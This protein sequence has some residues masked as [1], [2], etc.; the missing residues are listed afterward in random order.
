[1]P[2]SGRI[3]RFIKEYKESA[4]TER[5]SF[6][7][8]FLIL[9]LEVILI[10]HAISLRETFIIVLTSILLVISII[11]MILVSLEIHEHYQVSNFDRI[12][13]IRLDDFITE[14]RV[15]NVKKIVADFIYMYPEYEKNRTEIYHTTCQILETHKEEAIEKEIY[16]KLFTFV[17][18]K[19]RATVDEIVELF[20]SKYPKF[21]PYRIE[22]YEKTCQMKGLSYKS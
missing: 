12:L 18:R 1:M 16:N 19:K 13:T 10:A 5:V 14:K 11:E 15:K 20:V 17:K 22:I 6:F 3:R 21:K 2:R 8:P 7:P 9:A 4:R